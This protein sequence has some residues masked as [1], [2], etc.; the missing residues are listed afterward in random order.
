[1]GDG[2]R[3]D[4]RRPLGPKVPENLSNRLPIISN[5]LPIISNRL[6]IIS[7]RLPKISNRLPIISNRLP[8][9]QIDCRNL[10]STAN[11][12]IYIYIFIYGPARRRPG[13]SARRCCYRCCCRCMLFFDYMKIYT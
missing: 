13:W 1:M 10:K 2:C 3:F 7:N 9:S 8:K 11:S 5:R 12:D 6:P 4:V